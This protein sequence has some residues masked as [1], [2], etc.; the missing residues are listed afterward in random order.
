[1]IKKWYFIWCIYLYSFGSSIVNCYSLLRTSYSVRSAS[2]LTFRL[3]CAANSI[4]ISCCWHINNHHRVL[5]EKKKKQCILKKY[6]KTKPQQ[7]K[8]IPLKCIHT[9]EFWYNWISSFLVEINTYDHQSFTKV[10]NRIL[11]FGLNFPTFLLF[12]I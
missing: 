8:K 2:A 11:Y 4:C 10:F 6:N 1:M 5:N 12:L 7:K 9:D 3:L